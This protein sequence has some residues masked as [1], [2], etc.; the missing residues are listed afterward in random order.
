LFSVCKKV[1]AAICSGWGGPRGHDSASC[2]DRARPSS[3]PAHPLSAPP[4]IQPNQMPRVMRL[5]RFGSARLD[6]PEPALTNRARGKRAAWGPVAAAA[7]DRRRGS[8]TGT[9][10]SAIAGT[11][12]ASRGS[13]PLPA[14]S[15]APGGFAS[16]QPL[17]L[18]CR[19]IRLWIVAD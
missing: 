4:F 10:T 15:S 8:A 14:S 6:F 17:P 5:A 16:L 11:G 9:W 3:N 12:A 1:V 18:S 19:E 7:A 2:H 13:S